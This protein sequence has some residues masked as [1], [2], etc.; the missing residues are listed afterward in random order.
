MIYSMTGFGRSSIEDEKYG[1]S[2]EIKTVNNKYLDIQVK[3]PNFLNF[4]EEDIK[5]VCRKKLNRGRIEVYIRCFR[6]EKNISKIYFDENLIKNYI[7]AIGKLENTLERNFK[8]ELSD[9]LQ[10]EGALQI[11]ESDDDEDFLK[12]LVLKQINFALDLVL[13][14]RK[15]EGE[16]LSKTILSQLDQMK[17]I[18]LKIEELADSST[19]EYKA[20]LLKKFEDINYTNIKLDMDRIYLEVALYAERSDITEEIV[21]LKSHIKQFLQTLDSSNPMGRKLDFIVQEMNRE[22]NTISSKSPN[23]TIVKSCIELKTIIEKIREQI[24]NI[25]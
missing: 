8:F 7:N 23:N 1:V 22:V 9:I 16:N 18:T 3:N 19:E 21:R 24:Q 17:E 20:N 6:K 5:K 2:V 13:D 11:E 12:S 10:I 4:L 14:M 25:E 15:Q